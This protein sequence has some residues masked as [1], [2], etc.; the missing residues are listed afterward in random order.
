MGYGDLV[1][2][3]RPLPLARLHATVA[4]LPDATCGWRLL[5][6]ATEPG[7]QGTATAAGA[8]GAGGG[9]SQGTEGGKP[10]KRKR[11]EPDATPEAHVGAVLEGKVRDTRGWRPH[12]TRSFPAGLQED[13]SLGR[14]RSDASGHVPFGE[15]KWGGRGTVP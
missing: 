6:E 13:H 7:R 5:M 15:V 4:A 9:G 1:L 10:A 3:P 8:A 14:T 2:L 12:S 11:E